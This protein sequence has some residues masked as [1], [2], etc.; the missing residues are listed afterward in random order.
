MNKFS[1]FCI[2]LLLILGNYFQGYAQFSLSGEIR[3]RTEY[4]HGLKSLADTK[5]EPGFFTSQ[6]TRLNFDFADTTNNIK[7]GLVLQDVR[8]WG[9]QPQLVVADGLF[10][11]HQAWFNWNISPKISVKAGRQELVYDDHR[12][13]GNVGWAQQARSHDVAVF[14]YNQKVHLGIAWN[15][16][17]MVL[18]SNIYTTPK[19]Y[20]TFQYLWY[21]LG[22]KTNKLNF[23][24]LALNNGQPINIT[25]SLGNITK[26]T[27][28]YSQTLGGRVTYKLTDDLMLSSNNYFQIGLDG[29]GKDLNAYLTN[30]DVAYKIGDKF[31]LMAGFERQSGNSEIDQNAEVNN[32][33]TPFYGTNHKFNGWMDYFYVG[34][35]VG[36]VGLQDNYLI[37]TH[38]L[39]ENSRLIWAFHNFLSANTISNDNNGEASNSNSLGNELDLVY[40][41]KVNKVVVFKLGYSQVIATDNMEFLKGGDKGEVHNWAW[42]MV[43][44]KPSFIK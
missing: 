42:M 25:D 6:R 36:S 2:I 4:T 18:T 7:V 12:I 30:L 10:S 20:K 43:V 22:G 23:S 38:Q 13:F 9:N 8:T 11:I 1:Y 32:A 41:Q 27:I 34:N 44:V 40:I 21:H 33:F 29:S 5:Q 24:L 28:E 31:K 15:Q 26:Q 19:S 14:K 35:H 16:D 37:G 17:N 3:P 39:G